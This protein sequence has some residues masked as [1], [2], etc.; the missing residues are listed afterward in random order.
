MVPARNL[1]RQE[2]KPDVGF[3]EE[4]WFAD[5]KG[6]DVV[7]GRAGLQRGGVRARVEKKV[8]QRS[9][10]K[11]MKMKKKGVRVQKGIRGLLSKMNFFS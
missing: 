1:P 7:N 10:E 8:E 9:K 11:E 3:S 5:V 4:D 6:P 2:V